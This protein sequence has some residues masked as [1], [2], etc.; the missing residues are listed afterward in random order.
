MKNMWFITSFD[1]LQ[2]P[3]CLR[4][5]KTATHS[6]CITASYSWHLQWKSSWLLVNGV[7]ASSVRKTVQLYSSFHMPSRHSIFSLLLN[8]NHSVCHWVWL[9]VEITAAI[10]IW[11]RLIY[12]ETFNVGLSSAANFFFKYDSSRL[13]SLLCLLFHQHLQLHLSLQRHPSPSTTSVWA[14]GGCIWHH[15]I[16]KTFC[17]PNYH[18]Y[19]AI[20]NHIYLIHQSFMIELRRCCAHL[21]QQKLN[22]A[23]T[24]QRILRYLKYRIEH[25][26]CWFSLN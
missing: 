13:R 7:P 23:Q 5:M 21:V 12:S 18:I 6:I 3:K 2:W 9:S 8:L 22:R 17:Q 10:T 20:N 24:V 15:N 19:A 16:P 14:L 11:S 25:W 4:S 1:P 26:T